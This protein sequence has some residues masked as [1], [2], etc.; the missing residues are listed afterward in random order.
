MC[1]IDKCT[2]EFKKI[3]IW[4]SSNGVNI[5]S[6]ISLDKEIWFLGISC[7]RKLSVEA[8]HD[9]GDFPDETITKIMVHLLNLTMHKVITWVLKR[10]FA[11]CVRKE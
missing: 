5:K 3:E 7:I 11:C 9:W 2:L 10:V 1:L 8:D 4:K 6:L